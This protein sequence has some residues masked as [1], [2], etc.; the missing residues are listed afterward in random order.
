MNQTA[1]AVAGVYAVV[2]LS[3]AWLHVTLQTCRRRFLKCMCAKRLWHTGSTRICGN[4]SVASLAF[5][6]SVFSSTVHQW[7]YRVCQYMSEHSGW[8]A[9]VVFG[10]QFN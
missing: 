9:F 4:G 8:S 1:S 5:T 7:C 10:T 2:L 3:A 6:A